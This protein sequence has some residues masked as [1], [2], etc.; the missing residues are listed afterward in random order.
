VIFVRQRDGESEVLLQLRSGTGYMDGYWATA[1]AGHIEP[2]E[3]VA[4]AARREAAE[5]LGVQNLDLQPLCA[6]HRRQGTDPVGQRVDYFFLA[7]NW[8]GEPT[9]RE[10]AKCADLRWYRLT[11]L[12]DP[13]V[14]HELHVM[15]RHQENTLE[16]IVSFGF[17]SDQH[18]GS[19]PAGLTNGRV[20]H[21]PQPGRVRTTRRSDLNRL[22]SASLEFGSNWRRPVGELAVTVLAHLPAE[23]RAA[24]VDMVERCRT[25][26]EE[27]IERMHLEVQGTWSRPTYRLVEE[28]I[29]LR[30]PWMTAANRRRA[31]RQGQYYAWHDNG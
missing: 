15:L 27:E 26:I 3:S 6:M 16:P 24:L 4:D 5:E 23:E 12:P 2:G 8:K 25:E 20:G 7:T 28:W 29:A 21:R 13:V 18:Q 10:P 14:P 9:I 19:D 30:Y 22:Y 17:D 11:A 1:A 31:I